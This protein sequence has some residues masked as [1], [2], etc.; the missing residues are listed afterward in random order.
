MSVITV[1]GPKQMSYINP[2]SYEKALPRV[3]TANKTA[4]AVSPAATNTSARQSHFHQ[5]LQLNSSYEGLPKRIQF[6]EVCPAPVSMRMFS[7]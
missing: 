6:S 7:K 1:N 3:K 4:A 2:C 5:P